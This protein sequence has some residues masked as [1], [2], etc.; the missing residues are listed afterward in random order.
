MK[1]VAAVEGPNKQPWTDAKVPM[2]KVAAESRAE[3]P[4]RP[5]DTAA[6][7]RRGLGNERQTATATEGNTGPQPSML[8]EEILRE[9]NLSR[10]L[11]RVRANKGAPGV[12]G[13]TVDQLEEH[14]RQ[15]CTT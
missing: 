3:R 6:G 15:S 5:Q 11:K 9:E 2:T 14:L 8:M 7:S 10:A 1:A 4:E 13:M 12:D